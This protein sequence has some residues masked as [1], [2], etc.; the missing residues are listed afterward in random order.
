MVGSFN[1]FSQELNFED[2]VYLYTNRL[3]LEKCDS[4]L[5]KKNFVYD[6]KTEDAYWF[7]FERN[8]AKKSQAL[9]A[10]FPDRVHF[11]SLK[12]TTFDYYK[13]MA[14]NYAIKLIDSGEHNG[15]MFFE[16][17]SAKYWMYLGQGTDTDNLNQM[18]YFVGFMVH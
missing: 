1:S 5:A 17:D 2:L 16:Y 13:Q 9:I 4:Y 10:L 7:A 8:K 11:I 12:R 3:D 14:K 18:V 15:F 6:M